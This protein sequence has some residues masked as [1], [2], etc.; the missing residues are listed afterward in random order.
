MHTTD[1]KRR[2]KL[3]MNRKRRDNKKSTICRQVTG[4]HRCIALPE[5]HLSGCS[6]CRYGHFFGVRAE[7]Q[8]KGKRR[9]SSRCT[10]NAYSMPSRRKLRTAAL[11]L[12]HPPQLKLRFKLAA[13]KNR[14]FLRMRPR[15]EYRPRRPIR[16]SRTTS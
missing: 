3:G 7:V 11:K 13:P 9:N 8:R 5:F 6:S 12:T 10:K 14:Q 1:R 4:K 15:A 2:A 16:S